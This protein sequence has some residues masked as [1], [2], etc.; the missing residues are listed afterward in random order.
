MFQL[1]YKST[2]T[3][4]YTADDSSD[5]LIQSRRN[6]PLKNVTGALLYTGSFFVQALE[7]AEASVRDVYA[8]VKKDPRHTDIKCLIETE[9]E[10]AEFGAWSMAFERTQIGPG[11]DLEKQLA[12]LTENA[13]DETRAL[14]AKFLGKTKGKGK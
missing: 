9:V 10:E 4:L 1:I 14:F 13:S 7:G 5:I 8:K 6:N 3:K 12:G 2:P 11:A